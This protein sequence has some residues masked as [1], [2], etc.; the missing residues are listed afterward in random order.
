MQLRALLLHLSLFSSLLL[1]FLISIFSTEGLSLTLGNVH[2][3]TI[4]RMLN[5]NGVHAARPQFAKNH[6]D[7]PQGRNTLH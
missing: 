2:V 7:E 4:G 5:G 1:F 3:S 6:M